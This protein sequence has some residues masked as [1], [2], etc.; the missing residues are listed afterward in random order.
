M[1]FQRPKSGEPVYSDIDFMLLGLVLEHITGMS[2]DQYVKINIYQPLNLI[3]TL[4][5]PLNNTQYQKSEFAAT[6][7]KGSTRN[8]TINFPNVCKHVIQ[9]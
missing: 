4:F 7:F 5:N 6:E 3:H 8:D 2:I 9:G 1:K